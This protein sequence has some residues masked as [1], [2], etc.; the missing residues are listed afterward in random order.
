MEQDYIEGKTFDKLD[1]ERLLTKGEYENCTFSNCDFSNA[2]FS[3]IKF[4]ECEFKSC[5]L[6]LVKLINTALRF[7]KFQECKMLGLHFENCNDFGLSFS[8]D[9]CNLGQ[10]SFYHTKLKKTV[11]KK[12]LLHEAD[13][14]DCDL[15][16]SVFD[17]CD[18]TRATFE[19][20]VIEKV[21]FRTSFNYSID[22][23]INRI[24]KAKFSL[25]G[26]CGLLDKYDI[27][28]DQTS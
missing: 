7:V 25:H 23:A 10:C 12:S 13:F 24:K 22:P 18:L 1:R 19:N 21:D 15:N 2:D 26:V 3:N 17:H 27:E 8:F 28:I 14:T 4:V 6:S 20:T 9:D 16:G 5:N 11:F